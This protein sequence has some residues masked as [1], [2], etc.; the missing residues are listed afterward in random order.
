[1]YNIFCKNNGPASNLSDIFT[2]IRNRLFLLDTKRKTIK[3]YNQHLSLLYVN[4]IMYVTSNFSL[5]ASTGTIKII[6]RFSI[7][8]FVL[9]TAKHCAPIS[10][11]APSINIPLI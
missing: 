6:G 11:R 10:Q 8:M 7:N 2:N 3:D 9:E 5:V 1:M 4:G